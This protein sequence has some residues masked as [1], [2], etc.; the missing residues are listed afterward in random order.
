[1]RQT[2]PNAVTLNR[3]P[4]YGQFVQLILRIRSLPHPRNISLFKARSL[5]FKSC[6]N[7]TM[8]A[9]LIDKLGALFILR[10]CIV[11]KTRVGKFSPRLN[12]GRC[13]GLLH[14]DA[15][16]EI[17]DS[18]NS[19][20]DSHNTYANFLARRDPSRR[21]TPMG[22]FRRPFTHDRDLFCRR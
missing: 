20:D 2:N 17:V 5:V 12:M 22:N 14:L 13:K 11:R 1:M 21:S 19:S 6:G 8:E 3:P 7:G 10:I 15:S 4:R 16:T 18:R 9:H